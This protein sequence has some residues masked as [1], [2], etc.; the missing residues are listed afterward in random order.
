MQDLVSFTILF[1]ISNSH[2]RWR[3]SVHIENFENFENDLLEKIF[4]LLEMSLYL[5]ER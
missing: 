2:A 5:S 4:E 3:S 1:G